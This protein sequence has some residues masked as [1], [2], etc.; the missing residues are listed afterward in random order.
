[1]NVRRNQIH[2]CK[3]F[4]KKFHVEEPTYKDLLELLNGYELP[5]KTSKERFAAMI[6]SV[7][8]ELY[9]NEER[10]KEG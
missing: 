6:L 8:R 10:T 9:L 3:I 4:L 5:Y 7:V 1:M 2:N